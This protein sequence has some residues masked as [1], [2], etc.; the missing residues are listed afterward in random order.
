MPTWKRRL[1]CLR[2][3]RELALI[4]ARLVIRTFGGYI[5][6]ASSI[7]FT[8]ALPGSGLSYTR[9][10]MQAAVR[11]RWYEASMRPNPS[12]HLTFNPSLHL[13]FNPS[14]HLTFASRLRRLRRPQVNSNVRASLPAS[15]ATWQWE[16]HLKWRLVLPHAI[17][18]V[19]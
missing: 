2:S 18:D 6:R 7:T 14:L 1:R 8:T 3:N 15:V 17:N 19:L 13:T 9:F 5:C 4:P 12:L 10:G 16:A 11:A